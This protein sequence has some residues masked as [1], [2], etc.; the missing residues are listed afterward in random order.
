MES[1]H[2][3]FSLAP[4]FLIFRLFLFFFPFFLFG[5]RSFSAKP[6]SVSCVSIFFYFFILSTY[7][8][9]SIFGVRR[10]V[11]ALNAGAAAD[12]SSRFSNEIYTRV[13]AA[14]ATTPIS[15]T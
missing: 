8:E 5:L 6:P 3:N 10:R 15:C 11:H 7:M 13:I 12:I 9:R 14:T 4:Q 2:Y 1:I